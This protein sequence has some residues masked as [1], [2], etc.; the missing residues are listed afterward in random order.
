MSVLSMLWRTLFCLSLVAA[1]APTTHAQAYPNPQVPA[2]VGPK[3]YSQKAFNKIRPGSMLRSG[4]A[5]VPWVIVDLNGALG[6]HRDLEMTKHYARMA[7]MDVLADIMDKN[8]LS[9]FAERLETV[10]R[11]EMERFFDAMQEIRMRIITRSDDGR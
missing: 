6:H 3:D 1:Y 9:S 2:A 10:R 8:N 4:P 11:K 7:Q 5:E